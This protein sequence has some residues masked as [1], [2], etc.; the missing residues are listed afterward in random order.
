MVLPTSWLV[1]GWRPAVARGLPVI[2]L[3]RALRVPRSQLDKLIAGEALT[4]A[5]TAPAPQTAI[6][7]NKAPALG[8]LADQL[9]LLDPES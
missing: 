1:V 3:G 2:K 7:R 8:A 6:L 4:A 9:R 5:P